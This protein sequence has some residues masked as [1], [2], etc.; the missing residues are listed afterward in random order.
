M[1]RLSADFSL[2]KR[3]IFRVDYSPTQSQDTPDRVQL[4]VQPPRLH[5]TEPCGSQSDTGVAVQEGHSRTLLA[6]ARFTHNATTPAVRATD[7]IITTLPTVVFIYDLSGPT[8]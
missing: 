2:L 8:G 6:I 4:N 3:S 1:D 5:P 7:S